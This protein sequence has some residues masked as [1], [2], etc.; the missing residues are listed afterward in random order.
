MSTID[1]SEVA[2]SLPFDKTTTIGAQIN[3]DNTQ[4]AIER[5][6]SLVTSSS[7]SFTFCQYN[8]NAGAGRYLEF[9]SGNSSDGGPFV[10]I[11]PLLIVGCSIAANASTTASVGV[12]LKVGTV[13]TLLTSVS[14]TAQTV[15]YTSNLNIPMS[16]GDQ[17]SIKVI[18]GS[19]SKPFFAL[20]IAGA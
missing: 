6:F 17:I 4:D 12:Y 14:L 9:I 20:Y 18:S 8:G 11:Y 2:L 3:R 10:C 15:N 7:R 13:Y 16:A 5:V 1:K 19:I